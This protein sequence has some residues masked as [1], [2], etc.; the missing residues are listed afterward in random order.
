M[1]K[2]TLT[3]VHFLFLANCGVVTNERAPVCGGSPRAL[4]TVGMSKMRES[5]QGVGSTARRKR[6]GR[7]YRF[8]MCRPRLL[9]PD[10]KGNGAARELYPRGISDR[11]DGST[12]PRGKARARLNRPR[13]GST[14]AGRPIHDPLVTGSLAAGETAGPRYGQGAYLQL[15]SVSSDPR[16]FGR[17]AGGEGSGKRTY[18]G[19]P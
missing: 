6:Q 16:L 4:R 9:P 17:K 19:S 13:I 1:I 5:T 2:R 11:P 10:P 3:I 14:H 12:W 7:L 18:G 15:E 8:P